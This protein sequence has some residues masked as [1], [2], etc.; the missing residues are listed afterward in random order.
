[1][2]VSKN[3]HHDQFPATPFTRV[4]FA[5]KFGVSVEKVVATMDV[6]RSHHGIERPDKK[7]SSELL[8]AFRP[9]YI[10]MNSVNAIKAMTITQSIV[11]NDKLFS[12]SLFL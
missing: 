8:P 3:D 9:A 1:M 6:P 12:L 7:K 11:S 5:T 4:M 2:P 10:P